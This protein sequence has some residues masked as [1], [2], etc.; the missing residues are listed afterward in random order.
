MCDRA[1]VMITPKRTPT[2]RARRMIDRTLWS[3]S[4]AGRVGRLVVRPR[5]FRR[6]PEALGDPCRSC[7]RADC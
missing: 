2:W 6:P 7:E 3:D 4:S 5:R 1:S